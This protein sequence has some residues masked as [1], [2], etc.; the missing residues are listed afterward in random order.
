MLVK[1]ERLRILVRLGHDCN[2][3]IARD[4][5]RRRGDFNRIYILEGNEPALG[6]VNRNPYIVIEVRVEENV[7]GYGAL[8]F[9]G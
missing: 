9:Y 8:W 5:I 2:G 4:R 7:E 6:R 3:V 1:V